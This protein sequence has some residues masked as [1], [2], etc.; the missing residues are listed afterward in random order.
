MDQLLF[1]VRAFFR[2]VAGR[3]EP[4]PGGHRPESHSHWDPADRTWRAH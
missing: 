4:A 1:M 2:L 3:T